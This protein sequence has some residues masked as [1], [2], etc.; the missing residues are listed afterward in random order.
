M[1]CKDLY[2]VLSAPKSFSEQSTIPS[3]YPVDQPEGNSVPNMEPIALGITLLPSVELY[4]PPT[5]TDSRSECGK[6]NQVVPFETSEQDAVAQVMRDTGQKI[7]KLAPDLTT[8]TQPTSNSD[9]NEVEFILSVTRKKRRKRK[10]N[11]DQTEDYQH[12]SNPLTQAGHKACHQSL[13]AP[14]P[15]PNQNTPVSEYSSLQID[16]KVTLPASPA[17]PLIRQ[18]GTVLKTFPTVDES[19]SSSTATVPTISRV[20]ELARISEPLGLQHERIAT[21]A[22]T[23]LAPNALRKRRH[24]EE[25]ED[26]HLIDPELRKLD[27]QT[28]ETQQRADHSSLPMALASSYTAISSMPKSQVNTGL[29]SPNSTSISSR[30]ESCLNRSVSSLTPSSDQLRRPSLYG[31]P[32]WPSTGHDT[33][34]SI[35]NSSE[36]SS[37]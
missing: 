22:V 1:A 14:R 18:T 6:R 31:V 35:T 2:D 27:H 25:N 16:G 26:D 11:R 4:P 32:A 15:K 28:R 29:A 21:T 13:G 24:S 34:T 33:E 8:S 10:H 5:P 17:Y 3:T 9:Q 12:D 19:D 20:Q 23:K 37:S 36:Q 7:L 30:S